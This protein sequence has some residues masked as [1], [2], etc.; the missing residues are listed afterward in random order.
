M[1]PVLKTDTCG[2]RTT[3]IKRYLS[4]AE[5]EELVS[6]L[7]SQFADT[8]SER[9]R[10]VLDE[11]ARDLAGQIVPESFSEMLY[12]LARH[13]LAQHMAGQPFISHAR[14]LPSAVLCGDTGIR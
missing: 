12:L 2:P 9:I 11:G 4:I 14:R 6:L 5:V 1:N 13:R 7:Q 10:D 3:R 8:S